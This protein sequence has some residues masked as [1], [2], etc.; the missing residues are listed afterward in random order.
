M[1]HLG[2]S[3]SCL[4]LYLFSKLPASLPVLSSSY[5]QQIAEI[6][7]TTAITLYAPS[8][9]W[10]HSVARASP[11]FS[12]PFLLVVSCSVLAAAKFQTPAAPANR[13]EWGSTSWSC[14]TLLILQPQQ[15]C[16]T[17]RFSWML[18]HVKSNTKGT[19]GVYNASSYRCLEVEL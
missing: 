1:A 18:V 9:L 7:I 8:P 2:S 3:L 12:S 11:S 10:A 5:W 19:E 14:N 16:D 17:E 4:C 15:C 13:L 6:K